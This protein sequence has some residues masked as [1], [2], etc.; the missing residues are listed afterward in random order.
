MYLH[1]TSAGGRELPAVFFLYPVF[2]IKQNKLNLKLHPCRKKF[3]KPDNIKNNILSHYPA[4]PV[5]RDMRTSGNKMNISIENINFQTIHEKD[6]IHQG[7]NESFK[8]PFRVKKQG[9]C[10]RERVSLIKE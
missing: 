2:C 4:Q 1:G 9:K 3:S 5:R 8:H 6:T 10:L 7:H